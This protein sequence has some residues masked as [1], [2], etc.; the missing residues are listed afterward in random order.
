MIKTG[1][2]GSPQVHFYLPT[3]YLNYVEPEQLGFRFIYKIENGKLMICQSATIN[4]KSFL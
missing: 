3:K 2:C 1:V 4:L